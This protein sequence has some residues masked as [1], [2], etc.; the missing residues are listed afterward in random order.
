MCLAAGPGLVPLL[1]GPRTEVE[2]L[3]LLLVKGKKGA[4]S[5]PELLQVQ[6][7][8]SAEFGKVQSRTSSK[9]EGGAGGLLDAALWRAALKAFFGT[10]QKGGDFLVGML[11]PS[12]VS[13]VPCI[14]PSSLSLLGGGGGAFLGSGAAL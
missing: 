13:I 9:A 12:E 8:V 6:S 10:T 7:P 11:L 5:S 14:V 3:P 4:K 1:F 2:K